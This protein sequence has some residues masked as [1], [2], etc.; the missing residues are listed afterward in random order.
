MDSPESAYPGVFEKV[1]LAYPWY[2]CSDEHNRWSNNNFIA[3]TDWLRDT[4]L[5]VVKKGLADNE[6]DSEMMEMV[7]IR[8]LRGYRVAA[9]PGLF[10]HERLDR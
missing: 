10:T 2:I 3:K 8:N 9:G 6:S 4:V 7:L 1:T 5:P